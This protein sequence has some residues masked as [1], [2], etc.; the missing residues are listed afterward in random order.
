MA[1]EQKVVNTLAF[2]D[3]YY[4]TIS[5]AQILSQKPKMRSISFVSFCDSYTKAEAALN[6]LVYY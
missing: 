2:G 3:I 1:M 4:M 6:S 5:I